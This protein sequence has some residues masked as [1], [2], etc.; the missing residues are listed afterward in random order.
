MPARNIITNIIIVIIVVACLTA[1]VAAAK[2]LTITGPARVIDGDTVVVG[3]THVRLNGVDAA[4]RGTPAGE[5]AKQVMEAIVNGPLTC[6]LSGEH[7]WKRE[8]GFCT[9]AAGVDIN[10]AIIAQG[11]ALAC[12]RYDV[13]PFE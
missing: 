9:T 7:T 1:T 6:V 3:I 13:V 10:Q 5:H 12:P 4:E 8:V 11:A 2:P